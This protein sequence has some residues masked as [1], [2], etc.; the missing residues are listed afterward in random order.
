MDS[1]YTEAIDY[2]R[3]QY[4]G[5][6]EIGIILGTGLGGLTQKINIEKE[7]AYN[8]IPNFPISTVEGHFGKLIFGTLGN[9]KV[10]AMQGRFHYYEGYSMEQ[11]TFP[12]RIMKQLGIKK[13][14]I[15]NAGGGL[16]LDYENGDLVVLDDHIN[17]Q[18]A[19]PLTGMNDPEWGDRF[20]DMSAPYN[21]ELKQKA[22]EIGTRKGF[23]VHE[24]VYVAV[25]GPNLETRAEY[26]F[27]RL[28]GAD[29]VGMSTVPEVIVAN[30]MHLDVFAISVVTDMCDPDNLHATNIEDIIAVA[31]EAEPRLTALLAELIEGI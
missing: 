11:I 5:K 29:V 15:S 16:N 18:T 6:P 9:K 22:L 2:I 7:L 23:R 19:N 31:N 24:G 21:K 26:R 1:S 12:V 10:V 17:L 27:L 20:P 4:D 13:L 3:R 8:F 25:S 14:F 30:Q 28:I